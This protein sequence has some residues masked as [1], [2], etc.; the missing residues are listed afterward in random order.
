MSPSYPNLDGITIDTA[1][2]LVGLEIKDSVLNDPRALTISMGIVEH[3][4]DQFL[5]LSRRRDLDPGSL[6][7][8][9]KLILQQQN[10]KLGILLENSSNSSRSGRIEK[11]RQTSRG[12]R[13]DNLFTSSE[14][15]YAANARQ[16]AMA[17]A[18]EDPVASAKMKEV[19][20]KD[21]PSDIELVAGNLGVDRQTVEAVFG[22]T[23]FVVTRYSPEEFIDKFKCGAFVS[24][25]LSSGKNT[26]VFPQGG[27]PA[28]SR[29]TVRHESTHLFQN[30]SL[31]TGFCGLV[32]VGLLEGLTDLFANVGGVR[33]ILGKY[34]HAAISYPNNFYQFSYG[35]QARAI[36]SIV[37]VASSKESSIG[38]KDLVEAYKTGDTRCFD[39]AAVDIVGLKGRSDVAFMS[40]P[41][42]FSNPEFKEVSQNFGSPSHIIERALKLLP[43]ELRPNYNYGLERFGRYEIEQE[44]FHPLVD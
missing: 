2:A 22:K 3:A 26:A 4:R 35:E 27:D 44:P 40:V 15:S 7:K 42:H 13:A 19:A 41:M 16:L 30:K 18:A 8:S 36:T 10:K 43:R 1:K 31:G 38:P 37:S 9:T 32:D 39:Q 12:T 33:N 29:K 5:D 6:R 25:E 28:S 21:F 17:I 11:I 23:Q 34:L 20:R 24:T 14:S